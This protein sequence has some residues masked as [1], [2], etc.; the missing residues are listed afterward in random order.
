MKIRFFPDKIDE[1]SA[2]DAKLD[3]QKNLFTYKGFKK[4]LEK[5]LLKAKKTIGED[6]EAEI[7]FYL[8]VEHN[9]LDKAKMPI[10][11][12]GTPSGD[13]KNYLKKRI[14]D[15]KDI[16]A[17]GT[18]KFDESKGEI[19]FIE[20]AIEKGKAKRK[21]IKKQMDKWL[22]PSGFE[23]SF[24][25]V[26]NLDKEDTSQVGDQV[27]QMYDEE[28]QI[29][30]LDPKDKVQAMFIALKNGNYK[31]ENKPNQ[32]KE[33]RQKIKA[34]IDNWQTKYAL[35]S[36]Q[37]Q[38]A[39]KAKNANYD[40]ILDWLDN[41][42]DGTGDD[43][44]GL[45][46]IILKD[47]DGGKK[48]LAVIDITRFGLE[49]PGKID[50]MKGTNYSKI[51]KAIEVFS[52]EQSNLDR[53]RELFSGL[54]GMI[55]K[56]IEHHR[57][58]KVSTSKTKKQLAGFEQIYKDL[59]K[60][61][62]APEKVDLKKDKKSIHKDSQNI[63]GTKTLFDETAGNKESSELAKDVRDASVDDRAIRLAELLHRGKASNDDKTFGAVMKWLADNIFNELEDKY[64][65]ATD[66]LFKKKS[67][68]IGDILSV[69]KAGS[70]RTLY[71]LDKLKGH[72]SPYTKLAFALGLMGKTW[73]NNLAIVGGVDTHIEST[74]ERDDAMGLIIGGYDSKQIK[75]ILETQKDASTFEGAIKEYLE[76]KHPNMRRQIRAHMDIQVARES[77]DE[78][79]LNKANDDYLCSLIKRLKKESTLGRVDN[80]KLFSGIATW[81]ENATDKEREA[82]LDEDSNF[83][84]KLRD[85]AGSFS[86][87]GID[88]GDLAYIKEKL[89]TPQNPPEGK[90]TNAVF[91]QLEALVAKQETKSALSRWAQDKDMGQQ[92]KD[93]LFDNAVK[94]PQKAIV[95]KFCNDAD[96]KEWDEIEEKLKTAA[97][98]EKEAL[99]K[100]RA[101]IFKRGYDGLK[102]LMARAGVNH[103]V[104]KEIN[105]TIMSNGVKGPIYQKL[106]KLAKLPYSI[107]FGKD[108][109]K[110][111]N[112]LEPGSAEA[113]AIVADTD[114]IK[115]LQYKTLSSR[116]GIGSRKKEW[117][118]ISKELGL[119]P[120]YSN[121]KI[122]EDDKENLSK[123][124]NFKRK[125]RKNRAKLLTPDEI[126]QQQEEV[127]N[128]KKEPSFWAARLSY[129][130]KKG[131]FSRDEHTLLQTMFEAQKTGLVL[132]DIL[133]VLREL[134]A[135][136][137]DYIQD[138][139]KYAC[140]TIREAAK[141]NRAITAREVLVDSR[142]S[143]TL[144]RQ[145]KFSELEDLV[146]LMSAEDLL[147]EMFDF[148]SFKKW[149]G[150][151]EI[152]LE[153]IK[154][155]PNKEVAAAKQKALDGLNVQ[156]KRFDISPTFLEDIDRVLPPQ[157]AIKIKKAI[158]FKLGAELMADGDNASKKLFKQLG[159]FSEADIKLIG[160]D[161]K[162]ISD[163]E[164]QKQSET[165]L[166]WS[167]QSSRMLQRDIAAADFL[168]KG[169]ER[170]ERIPAIEG[171]LSERELEE[172]K[173]ALVKS[174][175]DAE[176]KL[177]QAQEKF[178]ARKAEYDAKLTNAI[179]ALT[180]AVFFTLSMASGVGAAVG[181]VQLVWAL[182]STAIQTTISQTMDMITKGDRSGGAR[183]KAEDFFFTALAD[184]AGAIT[185]LVGANLAFAL[186]VKA[187]GTFS[188]GTGPDGK[189][190]LS[191]WEN[192]LRTPFLK[193]AKGV[194]T[195]TFNDIGSKF[196]KNL[197]DEKDSM[198]SDPIGDF[199]KWGKTQIN[200]LPRKYLKSL[201]MT[202][203][204]TGVGA[205]SKE[206]GWD[207]LKFHNPDA[208]G[209][210]YKGD[211]SDFASNDARNAATLFGSDYSSF[212]NWFN[213]WGM[214][215][216]SPK[217]G[218][219]KAWG[220]G[221]DPIS[222]ITGI[223]SEAFKG[224]QSPE[225]RVALANSVV[226]GTMDGT[227]GIK[228]H[229]T[230][231][232]DKAIDSF[233]AFSGEPL[234]GAT[235]KKLQGMMEEAVKSANS[236]TQEEVLEVIDAGYG[237]NIL[238]DFTR[239]EI[240]SG[241]LELDVMNNIWQMIDRIGDGSNADNN[242]KFF[243]DTAKVLGITEDQIKLYRR[244]EHCKEF[245]SIVEFR[246]DYAKNNADYNRIFKN[247]AFVKQYI[248]DRNYD[249]YHPKQVQYTVNFDGQDLV[250]TKDL[251]NDL[252]G[253]Y[254]QWSELVE[255]GCKD[256]KLIF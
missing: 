174:L 182:A 94:N 107:D 13:W 113:A 29:H 57:K 251:E 10:L 41:Q 30:N 111:V 1:K 175:Q 202:T 16:D 205:L 135:E 118:L 210:Q 9:F 171:M 82:M 109:L 191:A 121:T 112:K 209:S 249:G 234:D 67:N 70:L 241:D 243:N 69:F 2:L 60:F 117:E 188:Q 229:L 36:P 76:K 145:V 38:E 216:A 158:R 231:L 222:G 119:K 164:V 147:Q 187:L 44:I 136:A 14:K 66:H 26:G 172:E 235:K 95:A 86:W 7:N 152:L 23:I 132:N 227:K 104:E 138:K 123:R 90:E 217:F 15:H 134:D 54:M 93:L 92:F 236:A 35:L 87:S 129:E 62:T 190:L 186:D 28:H 155:A 199:K 45:A 221:E 246:T 198:L 239:E 110:Y 242:L 197:T 24:R 34:F 83:M 73:R 254:A 248:D 47:D 126:K 244:E 80:N 194:L 218:G 196:V 5:D 106:V 161:I 195:S 61:L 85:M 32:E 116:L 220:A 179:A 176:Q 115:R 213:S 226:W 33:V 160:M 189:P 122:A 12:V 79:A 125:H 133:E 211:G 215:D 75:E 89:K 88:K 212:S 201:L 230:G 18:L 178:E 3:P 40:F 168:T 170:N 49:K 137:Y 166:Q 21:I 96:L 167:S 180:S 48:T 183:E 156:I 127:K 233:T 65:A 232:V 124:D 64:I 56:W 17:I 240:A 22:M 98:E 81:L 252:N 177:Q 185:G 150:Q 105:E 131:Y 224:L 237:A 97:G 99:E 59:E 153:E 50:K 219:R 37:Q 225:M 162:A 207:F 169:W 238:K 206:L 25:E 181:V 101:E 114:L 31:D 173:E 55:K 108:V 77:K 68:L 8:C 78:G 163:I 146:N 208:A 192:I 120:P 19:S 84:K 128:Q 52:K 6:P 203:A 43:G 149:I 142:K 71:L 58:D 91:D 63:T 253:I 247:E 204:A 165:G 103:D 140:K 20:L 157:K 102:G 51:C 141:S 245:V 100:K 184:Q 143:V 256:I 228:Q 27:E 148:D 11:I 4:Q 214:F 53:K 130:Y 72:E 151:K 250:N 74:V 42:E 193:T 223:F 46:G 144:K 159:G 255:M 39:L 139:D 200:S 154:N